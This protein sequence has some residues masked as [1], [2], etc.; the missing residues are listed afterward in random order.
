MLQFVTLPET[1]AASHAKIAAAREA[2]LAP[3]RPLV[4]RLADAMLE[5]TGSNRIVD[6]HAL[7]LRGFTRA[8]LSE[9]NVAA[10]RD[11]ANR[12]AERRIG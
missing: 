10:A 6:A 1:A 4:E 11:R 8:D 12:L 3:R 9:D 7:A 2:R 5:L